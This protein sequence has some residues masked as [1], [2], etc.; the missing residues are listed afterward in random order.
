MEQQE[1]KVARAIAEASAACPGMSR[2]RIERLADQL[3]RWDGIEPGE[4]ADPAPKFVSYS[5]F[6]RRPST[7]RILDRSEKTIR[8]AF[9]EGVYRFRLRHDGQY[10]MVGRPPNSQ[11]MEFISDPEGLL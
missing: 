2:D 7:G 1:A 10:R 11:V 8:A 9:P 5:F 6:P 3:W 4:P